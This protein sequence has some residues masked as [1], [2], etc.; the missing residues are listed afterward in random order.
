MVQQMLFS[1]KDLKGKIH[2]PNNFQRKME[3]YNPF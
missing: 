2:T 3:G 1:G